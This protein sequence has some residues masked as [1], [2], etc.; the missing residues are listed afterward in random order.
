M[1]KP[2]DTVLSYC[3]LTIDNLGI[4]TKCLERYRP[5]RKS[6]LALSSLCVCDQRCIRT[7]MQVA[8]TTLLWIDLTLVLVPS[9]GRWRSEEVKEA[10][11]HT[12]LKQARCSTW[13]H[14]IGKFLWL[15]CSRV[16]VAHCIPSHG[17]AYTVWSPTSCVRRLRSTSS[18]CQTFYSLEQQIHATMH[19]SKCTILLRR[20]RTSTQSDQ[21][22]SSSWT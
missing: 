7:A 17:R 14:I 12:L 18:L 21:Y 5:R 9:L 10:Y 8:S 13:A 15:S 1:I 19:L 11:A 3:C 22:T 6:A 16:C 4:Q 2:I 20:G